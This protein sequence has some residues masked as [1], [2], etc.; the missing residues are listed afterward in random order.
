[1]LKKLERS[2]GFHPSHFGPPNAI[3]PKKVITALSHC[4]GVVRGTGTVPSFKAFVL[5]IFHLA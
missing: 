5:F 3:I 4:A 2:W 1:M